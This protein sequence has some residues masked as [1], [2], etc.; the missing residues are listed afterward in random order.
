ML[1]PVVL[2]D[3]LLRPAVVLLP[4]VRVI[5]AGRRV[6]HALDGQRQRRHAQHHRRVHGSGRPAG[7]RRGHAGQEGHRGG[8]SRKPSSA[9]RREQGGRPLRGSPP[10]CWERPRPA[11]T[12]RQSCLLACVW[13]PGP[14]APTRREP[15][16]WRRAT[17]GLLGR[18]LPRRLLWRVRGRGHTPGVRRQPRSMAPSGYAN[19]NFRPQGCESA[20]EKRLLP[21]LDKAR[22]AA[23]RGKQPCPASRCVTGA[24]V[25]LAT[26]SS[27]SRSLH[28][29][30]QGAFR[31]PPHVAWLA[32]IERD[33]DERQVREQRLKNIRD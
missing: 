10:G 26:Q 5:G 29:R 14:R 25:A 22:T 1:A 16:V 9:P 12:C 2:Q 3:A 21:P 4:H 20:F 30:A 18:V 33:E 11:V 31:R 27:P 7:H 28:W 19:W 23:I 6:E 17:N 24:P 8:T 13:D 15:S 32:S